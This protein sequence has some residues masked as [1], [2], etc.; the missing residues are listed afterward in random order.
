MGKV[1]DAAMNAAREAIET[2]SSVSQSAS[3]SD[4][5]AIITRLIKKSEEA[6]QAAL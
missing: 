2:I 4:D 3:D 5:V 6:A 1:G